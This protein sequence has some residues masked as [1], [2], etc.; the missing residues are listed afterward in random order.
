MSENPAKN[1]PI[2]GKIPDPPNP[3]PHPG[4]GPPGPGPHP[5][6]RPP[7]PPGPPGPMTSLQESGQDVEETS[8][9]VILCECMKTGGVLII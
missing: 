4:P 9:S 3:G 1:P 5:G 7:G 8:N 2:G 6:P